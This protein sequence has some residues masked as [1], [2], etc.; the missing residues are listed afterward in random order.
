MIFHNKTSTILF[1][2][3]IITIAISSYIHAGSSATR[4]FRVSAILPPH[5]VTKTTEQLK[6]NIKKS[7]QN[8]LKIEYCKRFRNGKRVTVESVVMK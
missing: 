2:T 6:N 7:I 3:L 4:S 1:I 5:I 8:A